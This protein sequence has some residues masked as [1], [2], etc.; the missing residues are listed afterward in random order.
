MALSRI[1]SSA[2]RTYSASR[3][4]PLTRVCA[5]SRPLATSSSTLGAPIVGEDGGG[6]RGRRVEFDTASGE[7][8]VHTVESDATQL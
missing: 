4:S 2:G 3:A 6:G 1:G 5:T 8:E 7:L